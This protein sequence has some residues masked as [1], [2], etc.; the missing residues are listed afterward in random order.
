MMSYVNE[1]HKA[2]SVSK[3]SLHTFLRT[4][5]PFAPHVANE[6]YEKTGGNEIL[7]SLS[8]P[9]FSEELTKDDVVTIAVQVNGKLRATLEM[10]AGSNQAK[11]EAAARAEEHVAKYLEG[12][13]KKVIFVPDKLV[14][15]VV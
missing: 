9:E 4:L 3:D 12:E 14:N 13:V 15:F 6:L 8:W 7:E 10:D 5:V 2:K 1:L 11:V